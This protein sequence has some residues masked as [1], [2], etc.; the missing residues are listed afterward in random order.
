MFFNTY[1]FCLK[2]RYFLRNINLRNELSN[3]VKREI[4]EI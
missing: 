1:L 2:L 3:P 4:N